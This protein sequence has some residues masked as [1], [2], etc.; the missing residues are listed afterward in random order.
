MG[1]T[2]YMVAD[3]GLRIDKCPIEAAWSDDSCFLT[4]C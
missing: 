4:N 3:L 2:K 1:D